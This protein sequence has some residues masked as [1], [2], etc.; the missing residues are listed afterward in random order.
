MLKNVTA[1]LA[2][3]LKDNVFHLQPRKLC[4]NGEGE[5]N[6]RSWRRIDIVYIYS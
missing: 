6:Y 1:W 5:K 3:E 2:V 4:V